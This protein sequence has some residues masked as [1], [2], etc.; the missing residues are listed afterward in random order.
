M[1][2][3]R[4]ILGFFYN[5]YQVIFEMDIHKA[6]S[7]ISQANLDVYL[8]S[9]SEP[10]LI[11]INPT[12]FNRFTSMFTFYLGIY[13]FIVFFLML[14]IYII[15]FI[16]Y[17]KINKSLSPSTLRSFNILFR[18]LNI[19][20]LI[21]GIIFLIPCFLTYIVQILGIKDICHVTTI[22]LVPLSFHH[23][24]DF[25]ILMYFVTPFR[26]Y[27]L[28]KIRKEKIGTTTTTNAEVL[29]INV[30]SSN[31]HR[32]SVDITARRGSPIISGQR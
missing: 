30:I 2:K 32:M 12:Y 1:P 5:F 29:K 11:G 15:Y 16:Q 20:L 4:L 25:M 10:T 24:I 21:L 26:K 3:I 6:I 19:Q 27:I 28:K 7:T 13:L 17:R 8:L 18:V 31:G 22:M 9:L 23:T 14:S